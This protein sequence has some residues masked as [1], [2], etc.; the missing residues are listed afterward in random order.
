MTENG[1]SRTDIQRRKHG[2]EQRPEADGPSTPAPPASA[3]H[4]KPDDP[5][6]A[7][8]VHGQPETPV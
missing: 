2:E 4:G 6:Q 3:K 1:P 7:K 5:E 8:D